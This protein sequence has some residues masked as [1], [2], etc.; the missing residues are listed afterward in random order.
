MSNEVVASF[1]FAFT[2][3]WPVATLNETFAPG[4]KGVGMFFASFRGLQRD[5][6]NLHLKENQRN[7]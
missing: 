2:I 5:F 1:N 7:Q 3:F 6:S 4:K